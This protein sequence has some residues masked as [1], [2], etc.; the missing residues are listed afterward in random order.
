MSAMQNA[1]LDDERNSNNGV[2]VEGVN[3][4]TVMVEAL[5]QLRRSSGGGVGACQSTVAA[6]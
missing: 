6:E 3:G 2:T 4:R 1:P 5:R